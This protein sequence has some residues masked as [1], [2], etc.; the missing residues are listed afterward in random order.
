MKL[1][2][3]L[4]CMQQYDIN[5]RYTNGDPLECSMFDIADNVLEIPFVKC[6]HSRN[7]KYF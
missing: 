5:D 3:R 4:L 2:L 6:A 7:V 1:S